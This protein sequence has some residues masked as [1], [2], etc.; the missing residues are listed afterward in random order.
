MADRSGLRPGLSPRAKILLP[1]G[2][3]ALSALTVHRFFIAEPPPGPAVEIS[4]P[5]MGTSYTVRFDTTD[6]APTERVRLQ[7]AIEG[8]LEEVNGLMSTYDPASELMRFNARPTTE[9][10]P[11][12]ALTLE[13]LREAQRVSRASGGALDVTVAPLVEAW[14]FGSAGAPPEA[15]AD[16]VLAELVGRVGY[17]GLT[18]DEA[19]GTVTKA[20]PDLTVD[21]SAVAKGYAADRVTDTLASLGY[22]RV[23]VEV[24]GELRAGAPKADGSPWRVAIERPDVSGRSIHRVVEVSREAVATSGDYRNVYELDGV[25]YTHLI[26]PRSGRPAQH[27][28]ASV[29]VIHPSGTL[30]DA[31][32]TA[33]AVLGVDEGLVVAEREGLAAL[34]VTRV[35]E[36]FQGYAT[37]E[38]LA[39]FGP[40]ENGN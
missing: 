2:L 27:A 4:G 31:W 11:L 18:I 25:L 22:E 12:S 33:L 23:L 29:T 20:R 7:G 39:R 5:I 19:A 16:E 21:L 17:Q 9:P 35:D 15:P 38:F 8:R 30:A 13:V 3:L 32:A 24:G 28:G 26:D 1:L 34:F 40:P 36:T 6:L 37:A 10:E 14:G